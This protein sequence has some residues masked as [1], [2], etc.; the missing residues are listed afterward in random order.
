MEIVSQLS[1]CESTTTYTKS[2]AKK[3]KLSKFRN[4]DL[5]IFQSVNNLDHRP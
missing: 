5:K 2:D 1:V 3:H 4:A